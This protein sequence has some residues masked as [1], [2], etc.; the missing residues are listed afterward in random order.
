VVAAGVGEDTGGVTV[1]VGGEASDVVELPP[2]P[3]PAAKDKTDVAASMN[4]TRNNFDISQ[5]QLTNGKIAG[6]PRKTD[7]KN[8]ENYCTVGRDHVF[9]REGAVEE[10][11]LKITAC[12]GGLLPESPWAGTSASPA[13][14]PPPSHTASCQRPVK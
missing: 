11:R 9:R 10:S 12:M 1:V 2:P 7:K 14:P 3:Q 6:K 5:L 13:R 8:C 4:T